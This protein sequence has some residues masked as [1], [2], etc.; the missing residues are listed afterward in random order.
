MLPADTNG[1]TKVIEDRNGNCSFSNS[2]PRRSFASK[3]QPLSSSTTI[4]RN[5]KQKSDFSSPSFERKDYSNKEEPPPKPSRISKQ[6]LIQ[7]DLMQKELV[8]KNS[9]YIPSGS[10]S[11]NGSGDSVQSCHTGE[12][13]CSTPISTIQ[14]RPSGVVIKNPKYYGISSA[15]SQTTLK[16]VSYD[17]IVDDVSLAMSSMTNELPSAF[18]LDTFN[19][20]LLPP[21]EN[22]PLDTSALQGIHMLLMDSGSRILANHLTRV[23]LELTVQQLKENVDYVCKTGIE[24]CMLPHGHQHRLDLIDR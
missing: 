14:R 21:A 12:S 11:G 2:L 7:D 19:T 6:I 16:A 3:I 24:L 8:R 17:P 15:S 10:D 1:L 22:K 13:D 9:F 4:P 18:D 23:D 5:G 20:L